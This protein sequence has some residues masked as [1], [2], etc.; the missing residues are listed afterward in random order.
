MRSHQ[1]V[2]IY[3]SRLLDE[4]GGYKLTDITPGRIQQFKE[5]RLSQKTKRG[6]EYSVAAVN[7]ELQLLRAILNF[8][9]QEGLIIERTPF[10]RSTKPIIQ[11]ED[12]IRR[13]R[14]LSLEEESRLLKVCSDPVRQQIRPIVIC[15]LDTGMRKAEIL[16]LSWNQVDLENRVIHIH[17]LQTKTLRSRSVPITERLYCELQRL[18]NEFPNRE[19][20]I[21]ESEPKQLEPGDES[22]VL[23]SEVVEE[24]K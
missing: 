6:G 23:E 4:F 18:R 13:N 8:A 19:Q 14:V 15:A 9:K 12:E 3:L 22:E 20:F 24:T 16:S 11:K 7:R 17:P 1:M 2:K 5:D 21:P 10:E